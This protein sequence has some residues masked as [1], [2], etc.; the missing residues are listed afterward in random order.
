MTTPENTIPEKLFIPS[1]AL[2]LTPLSTFPTQ[3]EWKDLGKPP[4]F[5]KVQEADGLVLWHELTKNEIYLA[6]EDEEILSSGKVL[7]FAES[8][9]GQN[10]IAFNLSAMGYKPQM[11]R[12]IPFQEEDEGK[13]TLH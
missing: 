10:L 5:V 4:I 11:A 2:R 7:I 8:T 3:D 1:E 12:V 9:N 6:R 13:E